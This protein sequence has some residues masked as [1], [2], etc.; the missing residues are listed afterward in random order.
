[1]SSKNHAKNLNQKNRN[2]KKTEKNVISGREIREYF[3]ISKLEMLNS[4]YYSLK[5]RGEYSDSGIFRNPSNSAMADF[6]ELITE[7]VDVKA[8]YKSKVKI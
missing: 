8:Y 1:M 2:K 7:N 6:F 5:D 3:E 4:M